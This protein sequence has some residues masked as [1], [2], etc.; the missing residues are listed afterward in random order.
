MTTAATIAARLTLDKS[1]YDKGLG[2][3]DK[4]ASNFQSKMKTIGHGMSRVGG[5][6]TAA[7]TV[8]IV[9]GFGF[10]VNAASNYD[11]S[12]NKVNVVFGESAKEIE[13]WSKT[14]ATSM[15]ISQQAAL[16][17]TGTYGN[18][19]TALGMGQGDAA[20]MSTSL[21]GLASDLA[22][23]NNGNAPSKPFA[24]D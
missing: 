18:L 10:M 17:A 2:D 9:A 24:M 6:M 22:S 5:Q 16:E 13:T 8:P 21:V 11:E 19:F 7:F 12:L 15:G 1:D 14:S 23:F 4:Q 3:A 20:D